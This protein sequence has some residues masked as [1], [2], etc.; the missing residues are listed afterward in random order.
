MG[1]LFFHEK[2]GRGHNSYFLKILVTQQ[3]IVHQN[4]VTQS[5]SS[6]FQ[7]SADNFFIVIG[8]KFEIIYFYNVYGPRQI[9]RGHMPTVIGILKNVILKINLCP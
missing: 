2:I 8:T 6:L 3:F 4:E 1:P 7:L 9:S 5:C